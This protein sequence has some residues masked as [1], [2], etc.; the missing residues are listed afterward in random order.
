MN[1]IWGNSAGMD[2]G[3]LPIGL[4][5]LLAQNVLARDAYGRMTEYQKEKVHFH[6]QGGISG[7]EAMRRVMGTDFMNPSGMDE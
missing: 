2:A 7:D 5:A 3:A 1:P 4:A 6:M